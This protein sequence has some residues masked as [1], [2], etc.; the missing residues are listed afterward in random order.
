MEVRGGRA[1][2]LGGHYRVDGVCVTGQPG[3]EGRRFN[4][5]PDL[6]HSFSRWQRRSGGQEG[7]TNKANDK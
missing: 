4:F 5:I 6:L 7:T 1:L 3:L 2:G